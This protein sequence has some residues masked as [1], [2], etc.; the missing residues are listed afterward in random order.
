[1]KKYKIVIYADNEDKREKGLMFSNPLEK[2][3]CALF[4]F[5]R[6]GDH[7]FWNKDVSFPLNLVFCNMEREVLA[8]KKMDAESTKSCRAQNNNVK[9]VVEMIDGALDEIDIND[10]LIVDSNNEELYFINK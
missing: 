6:S 2:D 8:I 5:P 3:E 10:L 4:V 7:A 1:M 9:Y